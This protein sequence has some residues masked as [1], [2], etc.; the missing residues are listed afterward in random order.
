LDELGKPFLTET[1]IK[2]Q[3]LLIL[4]C[5]AVAATLNRRSGRICLAT[6]ADSRDGTV[7]PVVQTE[8]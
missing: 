8:Q 7:L 2:V 6:W 1:I 5:F 3:D 4:K